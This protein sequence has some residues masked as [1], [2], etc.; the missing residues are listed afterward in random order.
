MQRYHLQL[1][2]KKVNNVW[3]DTTQ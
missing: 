3:Q 2:E 1:E